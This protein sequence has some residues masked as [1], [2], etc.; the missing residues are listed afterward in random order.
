MFKALLTG[1]LA[2]GMVST[3]V[4]R[5]SAQSDVIQAEAEREIT[6]I[7]CSISQ[8]ETDLTAIRGELLNLSQIQANRYEVRDRYIQDRIQSYTNDLKDIVIWDPAEIAFDDASEAVNKGIGNTAAKVVGSGLKAAGASKKVFQTGA[9][10]ARALGK[11][12]FALAEF[13]DNWQGL[14]EKLVD[15]W[16]LNEQQ[17]AIDAASAE[18]AEVRKK[19]SS[20]VEASK[21]L[22]ELRL[23]KTSIWEAK[24]AIFTRPFYGLPTDCEE[25]KQSF[26]GVWAISG[27]M[28]EPYFEIRGSSAKML[29]PDDT[30][31]DCPTEISS[32]SYLSEDEAKFEIA[33]KCAQT[34]VVTHRFKKEDGGVNWTFC[35]NLQECT[36][37][38]GYIPRQIEKIAD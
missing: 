2:F 20:A 33:N 4:H 7:D 18:F 17:R 35:N 38:N 37:D 5:A 27:G 12:A 23:T 30:G 11:N 1:V 32:F 13:A 24:G 19:V 36:Q 29:Q 26:D 14:N 9:L 25:D 6:E 3:P 22:E 21:S 16:N 15:Y 28:G 10:V 34:F 31:L 8:I